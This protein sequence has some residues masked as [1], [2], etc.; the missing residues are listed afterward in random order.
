MVDG[1]SIKSVSDIL[2]IIDEG[3]HKTGDFI[4][5]EVI[6]ENKKLNIKLELEGVNKNE[7]SY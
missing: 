7:V 3:L 2:K 1:R 4:L 6:R 5:L